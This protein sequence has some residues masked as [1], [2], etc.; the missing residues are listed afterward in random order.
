MAVLHRWQSQLRWTPLTVRAAW[1]AIL[2]G[3]WLRSWR[4]LANRSLWTD[5]AALALNIV[6][7]SFLG[8]TPPLLYDQRAPIGFLIAEKIAVT[9]FG[10]T[11]FSL[12]LVPQLAGLLSLIL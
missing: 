4:Y 1:V 7:R 12:R 9:L 2:V 5:E 10:N 3:A 6:K 8:L 11:E